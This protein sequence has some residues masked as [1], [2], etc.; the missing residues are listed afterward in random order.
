MMRTKRRMAILAALAITQPLIAGDE[1]SIPYWTESLAKARDPSEQPFLATYRFGSK[2][3][4]FVAAHHVFTDDNPTT[5]LIRRAWSDISPTAVIVEGYPTEEGPNPADVLQSIQNRGM[6]AAAVFDKSEAVLAASLAVSRKV[7]FIGGEMSTPQQIDR[8]VAMGHRRDDAL[9]A[10]RL[11]MLGQGRRSGELPVGDAAA[12]SK[13][14]VDVSRA[15]AFMSKTEPVSEDQF[16]ADYMRIVGGDPVNDRNLAAR[17]DPGT[18]TSLQ[19]MSA[20]SMRA[21][22]EHLLATIEQQFAGSDRVL[23]VYGSG[24]WTTL[25]IELARRFGEPVINVEPNALTPK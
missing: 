19:R 13:A 9:F 23:V 1:S 6:P 3:L 4:G 21:R 18:S 8:V 22:D 7:P 15:V 10:L 2:V 5:R 25:S 16:R 24:H 14:F 11:S 12:F 20:D 17:T